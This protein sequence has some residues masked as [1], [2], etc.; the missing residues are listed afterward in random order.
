MQ[1]VIRG[2]NLTQQIGR[3]Q[4]PD[5]PRR[6][7]MTSNQP[8][9]GSGSQPAVAPE[10]RKELPKIGRND[11]CWCGTGKKYKHCHMRLDQA[12]V[13]AQSTA[14][15]ASEA[16][17]AAPKPAGVSLTGEQPAAKKKGDGQGISII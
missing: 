6:I 5:T 1:I 9:K 16:T 4:A 17:P 7:T 12:E 10:E 15:P 3:Q 13:P 14:K 2:D 11:P 8:F